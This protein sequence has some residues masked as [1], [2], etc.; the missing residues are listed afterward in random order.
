MLESLNS[1]EN[2]TFLED[3]VHDFINAVDQFINLYRQGLQGP[4]DCE[5]CG[6]EAHRLKTSCSL[7]GAPILTAICDEIERLARESDHAS[8][9]EKLKMIDGEYQA[10]LVN[11]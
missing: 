5:E 4:E 3:Q 11:I 8:I 2:P 6:K 1:P 10:F 7:V 9:N